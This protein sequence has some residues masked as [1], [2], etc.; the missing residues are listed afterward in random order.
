MLDVAALGEAVIDFSQCGIG[1]MGNPAY[2]MNPGGAPANCVV[3]GARLGAKNAFL[4]MVGEDLF[5][6]H[7]VQALKTV[8]IETGGLRY[9][10]AGST[11]LSFVSLDAQGE[12][13]FYFVPGNHAE[14]LLQPQEVAVELIDQA[15][16]FHVSCVYDAQDAGYRALLYAMDYAAAQGKILSCD[17]NYRPGRWPEND[18][19]ARAFY[20]EILSRC[21]LIKVSEEE[22]HII[23]GVPEEE[24]ARGAAELLQLGVEKKA[25]FV[26]LGKKGAYYATPQEHGYVE[27]FAVEAV[28]TTGCGDAF[29]GAVHYHLC[30][31]PQMPMAE[32]VRRANAV[33]ALCAMRRGAFDAMPDKETLEAF[34]QSQ[35]ELHTQGLL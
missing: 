35:K 3:A 30:H 18:G 6:H 21:H 1:P 33:G 32:M 26:T 31:A 7:I 34:L 28:D 23:T 16:I 25:V 29:M 12:R 11:R 27:G 22:M 17:P 20:R 24:V 15:K 9:T 8:G 14:R 5:G 10:Q 4:G 13:S 2:E 19:Y